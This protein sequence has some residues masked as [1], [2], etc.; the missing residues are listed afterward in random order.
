VDIASRK[1]L[2]KM[3]RGGIF[4]QLVWSPDGRSFTGT[5]NGLGPFWNIGALGRGNDKVST[6]SETERYNCTPD[7]LPDSRHILYSRGTIPDKNERAQLWMAA[8]D[9]RDRRMLYAEAGR[10]IYG[11]AASPDGC[12]YLFTRS[13]EDL[14]KV[15]HSQ[16]TMAI[17]RASDTPM[18]GD[19]NDSLRQRFPSA[20]SAVR[21]DLGAG[22]EP[23]WTRGDLSSSK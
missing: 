12:Y 20:K 3:P 22:W 8:P 18:L 21:L 11:G 19:E 23:Y 6:V 2:H 1:I 16:T 5:A 7:W 15:D 9:G 4:Q 17:I 13:V 14:G 10:H